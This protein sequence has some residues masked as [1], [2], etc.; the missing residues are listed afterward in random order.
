[1]AELLAQ[2]DADLTERVRA[3]TLEQAAKICDDYKRTGENTLEYCNET[4]DELAC[5]IRA[6]GTA[7]VR[8]NEIP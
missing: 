7:R 5:L 1:M 3:E 8:V 4:A 2:H 6:L